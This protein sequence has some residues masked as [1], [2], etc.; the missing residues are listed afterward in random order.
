MPHITI[1]PEIGFTSDV[2]TDPNRFVGRQALVEDCIK[3]INSRLG[4]IGLYGKR[5]VG[6]SSLLR[7][8]QQMALGDYT[9]AKNAGLDNVIPERPRT[10][11]T[12]Y[13]QCDSM[14]NNAAGLLSRLCNDQD[15][16]DGLLRLIP[17][18]GKEEI[19]FSRA[20]EMS[21]GLDLKVVNW[22]TKGIDTSKYA[23]TVEGNLVQTFRNYVNAAVQHT[24]KNRMGRDGLLILLDEFDVI[25]DKSGIASLI[26]S[27]SSES[28]KFGVCG[29]ADDLSSL[30]DDHASIERLL[31]EGALHVSPMPEDESQSIIY[32]AQSL[33]ANKIQFEDSV[34]NEIAKLSQGYPYLTQLIGKECV[35]EC[36]KAKTSL[37]GDDIFRAV[38]DDIKSGRA[39]PTLEKQ[40]QRAIG[41]SP[42]RQI[43]L[44]L[45]AEQD[46]DTTF[47]G[48]ELGRVVLKDIRT[49]AKDLEV[50][51]VDQLI[52]RLIDKN[53]GPVLR[54]TGEKQGVYEFVNPVFRVY[55]QLRNF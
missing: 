23:K 47:Y 42:G 38:K 8:I 30:V 3:S 49:D 26:K 46:T 50:D 41:D 27:L 9:L 18:D 6:K 1:D 14:I 35:N 43:L 21:G 24:V 4:L 31:E 55:V 7:Q 53:F 15:S 39:F 37:V 13:Y 51:Y 11:L 54:R 44:H 32:T 12:V 5:G 20:S 36:N 33:F 45:L 48:E 29:I 2:I 17:N 34:T 19:E 40:Y 16:E 10:Y 25:E 28:V 22:G 52:P